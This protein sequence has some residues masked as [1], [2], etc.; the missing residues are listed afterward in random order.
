MKKVFTTG[1]VAKICKVAPRTVSKWFDSGR[2]RG[3]RIPGSQ[4]RRIPR[5][6]LIKFL[7]EH[8]MPLGELEEEE[9][10]KVLVIGAEKL[11][12]ERLREILPEDED[13]KYEIAQSGFEA[14]IMAE[15][16]HPDTIVIDLG[17]G[18]SESVQITANLRKNEAYTQT[19]IIGLAGEDEAEPE[20]LK[21][22]GFDDVFKKPFDV[23]LLGER[24]RTVAEAKRES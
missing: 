17:L 18:R 6:Q 12:I 13:Y 1:Q 5:E 3:Y 9:W 24:I 4:D 7:K 14:G 8:G 23:A 2:L 20:K 22:Y 21:E 11:F 10:H 19:L 15:S 16:F